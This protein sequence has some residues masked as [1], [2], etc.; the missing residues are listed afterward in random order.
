[1]NEPFHMKGNPGYKELCLIRYALNNRL[2]EAKH[3]TIKQW[4]EGHFIENCELREEWTNISEKIHSA[5]QIFIL[6]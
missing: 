4:K 3:N 1:M 6:Y 2:S 5:T